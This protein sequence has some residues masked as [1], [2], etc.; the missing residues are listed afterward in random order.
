MGRDTLEKA[1][2]NVKCIYINV[3]QGDTSHHNVRTTPDKANRGYKHSEHIGKTIADVVLQAYMKTTPV[4]G[5][6]VRFAQNDTEIASSRVDKLMLPETERIIS[7]HE[8]GRMDANSVM[9]MALTT[10]VVETYRMKRLETDPDLFTLDLVAIRFGD[11]SIAG[12]PGEPFTDV[13]MHIKEDSEFKITPVFCCANGYEGYFPMQS[14]YDEGGC[15][16]RS[17]NFKPSVAETIIK[18]SVDVLRGLK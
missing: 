11:V 1:S 7:L 16:T 3:A 12:V 13:G 15:E 10:L 4:K 9:G 14:A 8:S 18:G 2:D 17:L 6:P 5:K